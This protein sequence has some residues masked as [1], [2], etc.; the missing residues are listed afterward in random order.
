MIGLVQADHVFQQR[1]FSAAAAADDGK[2]LS[3]VDRKIDVPKDDVISIGG[4]QT[5]HGH[6]LCLLLR[7]DAPA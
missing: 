1:R 7:H 6:G 2:Y 5:F 3:L 4:N